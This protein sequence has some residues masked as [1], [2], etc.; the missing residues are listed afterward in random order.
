[1]SAATAQLWAMA[2]VLS[3]SDEAAQAEARAEEKDAA[4]REA[5]FIPL[6]EAIVKLADHPELRL[7]LGINARHYAES[8]VASD[9]VL[10]RLEDEL[11]AQVYGDPLAAAFH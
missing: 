9:S 11:E 3:A 6:A 10:G 5:G 8:H 1:M 4:M 7:Q 2:V